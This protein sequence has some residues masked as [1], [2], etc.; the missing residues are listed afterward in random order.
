MELSTEAWCALLSTKQTASRERV[1]VTGCGARKLKIPREEWELHFKGFRGLGFK[2][3]T[4]IEIIK[5]PSGGPAVDVPEWAQARLAKREGEGCCVT[6]RGG[7]RFLKKL[8]LTKMDSRIPGSV[9]TDIFSYDLVERAYSVNTDIDEISFAGLEE[10]LSRCGRF[11][12]DP[13]SAFKGV[14][15]RTGMLARRDLLGATTLSDDAEGASLRLGIVSSQKENGSWDDSALATAFNV[16]RLL[17]TGAPTMDRAV[18]SAC[19]WL[20]SCSQP[21][22]FPGLFMLDEKL[23]ERFN[24]WKSSQPRGKS[25]RPHRESTAKEKQRYLVERDVFA[26]VSASPCELRLTWTSAVALEALLRA[27]K[28]EAPRVVK[29]INTLMAMTNGWGWCGCGYFDTREQNYVEESDAQVDFNRFPVATKNREHGLD[30]FDGPAEIARYACGTNRYAVKTG[31]KSALLARKYTSSGECAM[32]MRRALA[33]HPEYP[34]SSFETN[35]A[36]ACTHYQN[37]YG[38][39]GDAYFS[40]VCGILER[41]YL[42]LSA[43]LLLR[44]VPMLIREQG[45]DG[46]WEER[47]ANDCPPPKREESSYLILKALRRFRFLDELRG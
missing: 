5:K 1:V 8:H 20:M 10:L 21:V 39:W 18:E 30:W 17:D 27:G 35:V 37:S 19:A 33:F 7:K 16:V 25:G 45:K 46:L 36:L 34:G 23:A 6:E 38:L 12:K 32:A 42:P 14:P 26:S 4:E 9:V 31:P 2:K 44:S 28:H 40:S 11:R 29:A 22:G 47:P 13:L 43:F 24:K 3:G 15:G 41:T